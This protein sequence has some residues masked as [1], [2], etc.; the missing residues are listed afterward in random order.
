MEEI[1]IMR[2]YAS[3]RGGWQQQQQKKKE[4]KK[5]KIGNKQ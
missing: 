3:E 1:P 2:E 5:K 4:K